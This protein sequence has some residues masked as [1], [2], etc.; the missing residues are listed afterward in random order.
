MHEQTDKAERALTSI[1]RSGNAML[2]DIVKSV[3]RAANPEKIVLFGS[4]ARRNG[5]A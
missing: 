3:V 2:A 4:A 5:T 1:F